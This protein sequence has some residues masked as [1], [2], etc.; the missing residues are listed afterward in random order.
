MKKILLL[1]AV[2]PFFLQSLAQNP[3]T[4]SKNK[5]TIVRTNV[6]ENLGDEQFLKI[7][8]LIYKSV[9][10]G[11]NGKT[12]NAYQDISLKTLLTPEEILLKGAVE[13]TV[14]IPVDKDIYI[15]SVISI[16]FNPNNMKSCRLFQDITKSDKILKYS[17]EMIGI[18]LTYELI[19]TGMSIGDVDIFYV[20]FADL[21]TLLDEKTYNELVNA[22]YP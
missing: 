11:I 20:T 12:I 9:T 15:D 10:T 3:E 21:K 22:C 19:I 8:N 6:R 14:Q 17:A 13:E 18:S 16:A 2:A 1:L 4:G 7:S 5:R